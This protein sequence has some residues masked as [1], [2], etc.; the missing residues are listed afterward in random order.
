MTFQMLKMEYYFKRNVIYNK[1]II[2]VRNE[3]E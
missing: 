2:F 1:E 3:E